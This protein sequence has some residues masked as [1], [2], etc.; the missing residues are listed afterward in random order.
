MA[1]GL[2]VLGSLES[3][4]VEELVREGVA[5]WV[6]HSG[7]EDEVYAAIERCM[8][9]PAEELEIMRRR[10]KEAALRLSPEAIAE[11]VIAAVGRCLAAS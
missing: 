5:G 9:T 1:C 11:Q 10:A 8:N 4:A 2:P 3:Q 7:Q 6:F